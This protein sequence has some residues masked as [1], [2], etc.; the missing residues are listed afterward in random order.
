MVISVQTLIQS[1][2][3]PGPQG[4]S[5]YS[6]FAG[7]SN[8]INAID[9]NSTTTLYPVMVAGTGDQTAKIDT[10]TF[11]YNAST[12]TLTVDGITQL[13]SYRETSSS[14][15]ISANTLT[16]DLS[17]ATLFNVS[18]NS[19][20]TTLTLTNVATSTKVSTFTLVFTA[21]G[22]AR[23]V[24]WP[25]SFN[26]PDGVAPT[27]TS[28]LNKKDVFTFFTSDGGTTWLAFTSGQ[29]L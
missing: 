6:G 15:T 12:S 16:L 24:T 13:K 28:T 11:V 9:D 17:I 23:S 29:N 18:L 21:D 20:I 14:P 22:T 5:G 19:N 27:L 3:P 4:I 10:P 7:P 2:L 1:N 8:I 25:V 26:W